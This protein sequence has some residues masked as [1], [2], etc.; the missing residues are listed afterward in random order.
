MSQQAARGA[1]QL[2]ERADTMLQW[3]CGAL[4]MA[5]DEVQAHQVL[6]LELCGKYTA[7]DIAM[8]TE[9]KA[10][11]NHPHCRSLIN[12]L[13]RGG[14]DAR[15]TFTIEANY[16][17]ITLALYIFFPFLNPDIWKA[18]H[19]PQPPKM[20]NFYDVMGLVMNITALERSRLS[21]FAE[22]QRKPGDI[23]PVPSLL[24]RPGRL[25]QVVELHADAA[26][27]VDTMSPLQ[28]FYAA[29]AVK[30]ITRA[31][32]HMLLI[33]LYVLLIFLTFKNPDVLDELRANPN[34]PWTEKLPLLSLPDPY[35]WVEYLWLVWEASM[36]F[37][38]RH[39]RMMMVGMVSLGGGAK[40]ASTNILQHLGELLLLAAI[41][42]RVC[43]EFR[44]I[45]LDIYP[46]DP[47]EASPIDDYWKWSTSTGCN[48]YDESRRLYVVY[49]TLISIKVIESGIRSFDF[50][51]DYEDLG[52]LIIVIKEM[53]GDIFLFS[54][55]LVVSTLS[56]M[57]AMAAQQS[58]G[59][60]RAVLEDNP[61]DPFST[62][63][64]FWAPLWNTFG[65]YELDN[66]TG[67]PATILTWL[68][69]FISIIVLVNL[70]VAMFSDTFQ[71][72][73]SQ[74]SIEFIFLDC[75]RMFKYRD[76]VLSAP[77][78]L[79]LPF[80]LWDAGTRLHER[81]SLYCRAS[82]LKR[83]SKRCGAESQ[84]DPTTQRPNSPP[85]DAPI[86]RRKSSRK[87]RAGAH[88]GKQKIP[89]QQKWQAK[90]QVID[91]KLYV[92][93]YIKQQ[94]QLPDHRP[95]DIARSIIS[96]FDAA[97]EARGED[98]RALKNLVLNLVRKVDALDGFV[99]ELDLDSGQSYPGRSQVSLSG[100]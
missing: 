46:C 95:Q 3:A 22:S 71:R 87:K 15:S 79:N 36:F 21:K 89:S 51:N 63:G 69:S 14:A 49:Q 86:S 98:T 81:Y 67:V 68:Y 42:V 57:L 62:H 7:L 39:Q 99:R 85:S 6:K 52:V 77:P 75:H 23:N 45:Q 33:A 12:E 54:F 97:G 64:A 11:L 100:E 78:I 59:N 65:W 25:R 70:L 16:S 5:Y 74:A 1:A 43:M 18:K 82:K 41:G 48:A 30:F 93:T 47:Y 34:I 56:F 50:L 76:V 29:P 92:E 8:H 84:L 40:G 72:V 2:E 53:T 24:P 31:I 55:I 20:G 91:G 58:A 61:Y 4:D 88:A 80:I 10:F 13:W 26:H 37:D 27:P 35:S 28:S 94:D 96:G 32:V 90:S 38:M 73:K 44:K 9:G 66:Y 19:G 60:Y 17:N 83:A